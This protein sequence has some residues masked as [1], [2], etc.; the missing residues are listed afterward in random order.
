M[1]GTR[2]SRSA[3][4]IPAASDRRSRAARPTSMRSRPRPRTRP[5]SSPS[6]TPGP[7]GPGTAPEKAGDC[8]ESRLSAAVERRRCRHWPCCLG[9]PQ[10][11]AGVLGHSVRGPWRVVDDLHP[12]VLDA[13]DLEQVLAHVGHHLAGHRAAE[14]G[15]GHLDVDALLLLVDVDLV[16]QSQV[17]DVDRDLRVEALVQL[18][19]HGALRDFDDRAH[20]GFSTGRPASFQ[21][22]IPPCRLTTSGTPS[23]T[24]ISE[25]SAERSPTAHWKTTLPGSGCP[26]GLASSAL[27]TRCLA[28]GMWPRCHSQ[29]SRTSINS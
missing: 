19:Q 1:S 25:A 16:D 20:S 28:P 9:H 2:G 22:L 26:R 7:A 29:S 4:A 8:R 17:D 13:R 18:L 11:P 23:A 21:A 27:S 24:A 6:T 10:F 12:S 14:G 15:E 5:G 3:A